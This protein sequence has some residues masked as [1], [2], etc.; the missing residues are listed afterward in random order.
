MTRIDD[1]DS[2]R[3]SE[4]RAAEKRN[5][6]DRLDKKSLE[7]RQQFAR[8]VNKK[9]EENR[10]SG[11]RADQQSKQARSSR[12]SMM[13]TREGI[14]H[15]FVAQLQKR[16][17][18]AL[19]K[20]EKD[21]G[22]REDERMENAGQEDKST[23]KSS[24]AKG[25]RLAAIARDDKEAQKHDRGSNFGGQQKGSS[26]EQGSNL[27]G[28]G[29]TQFQFQQ[30]ATVQ[31]AS[32]GSA[33]TQ[34]Q[35]INELVKNIRTGV[36]AKGIGVVQIDLKDTVLSGASLLV[37]SNQNGIAVKFAAQDPNIARLLSSGGTAHELKSAL[38]DQ[39]INLDTLEVN[40]Q[41]V[42]R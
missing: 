15:N 38:G 26:Q 12:Q 23:Q 28:M 8:M 21:K 36:D 7:N 27:G 42:L 17:D 14:E 5:E 31:S 6:A 22:K 34:R 10:G 37:T 35:L 30:T 24:A 25:D 3:I 29:K 4:Q 13:A 2:Q 9:Q 33:M 39:G 16:A 19:Q 41:K 1:N 40:G 32:G 20:V 11:Q 18:K